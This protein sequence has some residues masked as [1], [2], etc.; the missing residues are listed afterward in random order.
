MGGLTAMEIVPRDQGSHFQV[1][2]AIFYFEKF[3][4]TIES[5]NRQVIE[6][7]SLKTPYC[8]WSR[9]TL[10]GPVPQKGKDQDPWFGSWLE[11]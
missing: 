11:V 2:H 10:M 3:S 1:V 7:E 9:F 6:I 8:C 5:S 4:E